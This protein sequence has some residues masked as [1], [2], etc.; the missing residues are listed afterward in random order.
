MIKTIKETVEQETIIGYKCNKCG[1]EA[2]F[3]GDRCFDA[4]EYL[5]WRTQGGYGSIFGDGS[6][7]SLQL[8]QQCIKELL[9]PYL[10]ID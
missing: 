5:S 1:K 7:I 9:G 6:T 8:C 2:T 3:E 4:Q 10:Q